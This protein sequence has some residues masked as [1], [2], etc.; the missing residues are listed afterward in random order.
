MVRTPHFHCRGHKFDAWL[1][2]KILHTPQHDQ[3]KKLLEIKPD[4]VGNCRG[5]E[6]DPWAR[7]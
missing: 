5:Q 2:T 3:K 4:A 1:G 7:N 6:S